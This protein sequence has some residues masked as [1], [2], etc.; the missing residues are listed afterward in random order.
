MGGDRGAFE[1]EPVVAEEGEGR[2]EEGADEE[3]GEEV[4]GARLGRE[5]EQV[6]HQHRAAD[7]VR[8]AHLPAAAAPARGGSS[9]RPRGGAPPGPVSA[10]DENGWG[11]GWVGGGGVRI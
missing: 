8:L 6:V 10:E 9:A 2:C 11:M 1:E 3:D 4:G 7:D 5:L